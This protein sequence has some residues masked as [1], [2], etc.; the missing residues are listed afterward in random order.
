VPVFG[1]P[2]E[3]R[4]LRAD[5]AI[6]IEPIV[7]LGSPD[8]VEDADGWTLRTA[9]GRWAAQFEHTVLVTRKGCEI[10]TLT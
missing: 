5:T 4:R 2:G 3:G 10:L 8:L 6:T 7:V 1:A 9:D